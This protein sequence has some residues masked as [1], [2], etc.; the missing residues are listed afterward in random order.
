MNATIKQTIV[1][2]R[3]IRNFVDT[4]IDEALLNELLEKAAYA[5]FHNKVEPW[6]VIVVDDYETKM[7][8][9]EK[10]FESYE[11]NNILK[12]VSESNLEKLRASYKEA[13]VTPAVSLIVSADQFDDEKQS[14]EAL[15]ATCAFI[16]N[17]QL[18][19]WEEGIGVVWRSNPFIFDPEFAKELGVPADQKIV[20]ALQVGYFDEEKKPKTKKR[21]ELTEW[22][23]KAKIP[24]YDKK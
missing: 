14:F 23:Q 8:F 11:R 22:V 13:L 15:A 16:Q 9:L 6:H 2:R 21:R 20:G 24:Q 3:T 7:H 5:P 18:L 19:A 4:P 10:V 12:D 1:E 17:C